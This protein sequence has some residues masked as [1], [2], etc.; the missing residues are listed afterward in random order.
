MKNR[1]TF[2]LLTALL[3]LVISCDSGRIYEDFRNVNGSWYLQDPVTFEF[4]IDEADKAPYDLSLHV[5][6]DLDYNYYNLY[7]QF[8]LLDS[9]GK[10]IRDE[11]KEVI[12]FEPK[13]GRPLGSGLGSTFDITGVIEQG[14]SLE[15]GKYVANIYQ[16]MRTD[17]LSN[18]QRL[19]LKLSTSDP[20]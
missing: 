16:F 20:Q 12:L 2:F 17:T 9:E 18:V 7:Y 11:L 13:T 15:T 14:L 1:I 3:V 19:G 5:K 8:E 10:K 4:E 6:Y